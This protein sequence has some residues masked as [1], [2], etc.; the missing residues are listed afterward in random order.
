MILVLPVTVAQ[1]RARCHVEF[2]VGSEK[3]PDVPVDAGEAT[4]DVVLQLPV[5]LPDAGE[6]TGI[7]LHAFDNGHRLDMLALENETEGRVL[8]DGQDAAE[9]VRVVLDRPANVRVLPEPRVEAVVS[10]PDAIYRQVKPRSRDRVAM[11]R[12]GAERQEV[13]LV[14]ERE[15]ALLR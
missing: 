12:P 9:I 14:G 4:G 7:T 2:R 10:V 8:V 15:A 13:L 5:E 3:L 1:Q 6:L 11:A